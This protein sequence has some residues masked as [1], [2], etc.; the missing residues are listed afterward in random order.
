M[1]AQAQRNDRPRGRE[2]SSTNASQR[3]SQAFFAQLGGFE[4]AGK[5]KFSVP[6][7]KSLGP[8]K[9]AS[10]TLVPPET[11][12]RYTGSRASTMTSRQ[13]SIQISTSASFKWFR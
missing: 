2:R 3:A 6:I 8:L 13:L 5:T 10:C 1:L 9:D 7:G 11:S 4:A 12:S